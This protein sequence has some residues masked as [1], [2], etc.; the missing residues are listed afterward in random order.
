MSG[1]GTG[2]WGCQLCTFDNSAS[3]NVCAMC[4][5]G[6][7]PADAVYR[8]TLIDDDMHGTAY[9]MDRSQSDAGC[10]TGGNGAGSVPIAPAQPGMDN[11]SLG[12]MLGAI[13]GAS[14]ALL[15]G[16]AVT[17]GA[18]SGAAY[19]AVGGMLMNQSD[20]MNFG[21]RHD[22]DG[23][24]AQNYGNDGSRY[25]QSSSSSNSNRSFGENIVYQFGNVSPSYAT[26][27]YYLFGESLGSFPVSHRGM[28]SEDLDMSYENLIARFGSGHEQTPAAENFIR[29]LPTSNFSCC[30]GDQNLKRTGDKKLDAKD[31]CSI[32]IE[33]YQSGEE[34]TT[35]PCLHLFHSDC[36]NKWLRQSSNCPI[37]KY[38][39]EKM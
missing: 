33:D 20:R 9:Y 13:G 16:R 4:E 17:S 11:I 2:G 30:G 19:G 22:T 1:A 34:I 26:S 21:E 37:C 15:R 6:T 23:A 5:G 24:A 36:I 39:F 18:L 28:I 10:R 8:E 32:C 35:L 38:S 25:T 12:I 29:S 27:S 3:D 31:S 7:R 14:L